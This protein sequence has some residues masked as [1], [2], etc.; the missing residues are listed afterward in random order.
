MRSWLIILIGLSITWHY[1]DIASKSSFY[2][3]ALPCL[4][5]LFLL[6][7]VIK[8]AIKLGSGNHHNDG[9]GFGSHDGGGD[10]GGGGD[11]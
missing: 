1:L 5:L 2:S 6:A 7:A 4:F 10:S 3:I 11:C 9:G 8:L